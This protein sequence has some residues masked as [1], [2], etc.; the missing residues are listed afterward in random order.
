MAQI[1]IRSQSKDI[2]NEELEGFFTSM[3]N[4]A[5]DKSPIWSGAYVKSHSFKADNTRSRG[6]RIDG[7]NWRFRKKTGS[8]ADRE[9]GRSLLIG[10]IKTVLSKNNPFKTKVYTLR[11]DSNHAG[12]VENGVEGGAHPPGPKPIN[13]YKIFAKLRSLYG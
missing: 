1:S 9:E 11:N 4:Y 13:G 6:R 12:F 2:L 3:A 8:E 10:D 5:I 7:S